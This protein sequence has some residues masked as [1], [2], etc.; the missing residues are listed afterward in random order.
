MFINISIPLSIYSE[1]LLI[2]KPRIC[3][4]FKEIAQHCMI[5]IK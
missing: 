5:G 2:R 3:K 1:L 4:Y